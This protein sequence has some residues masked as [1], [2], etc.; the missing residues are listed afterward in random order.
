MT[1]EIVR[2]YP[3]L[4]ICHSMVNQAILLSILLWN[5]KRK[6][7]A[8]AKWKIRKTLALAINNISQI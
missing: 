2:R 3:F 1:W 6:L 7:I 5:L 8:M 4:F